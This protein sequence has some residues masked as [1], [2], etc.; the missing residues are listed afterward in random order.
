[1]SEE[2]KISPKMEEMEEK[3][4]VNTSED[5]SSDVTS[6]EVKNNPTKK[7]SPMAMILGGFVLAVVVGFFIFYAV[8]SAQ[9]KKISRSDF[10]VKSATLFHIPVASIDGKK[11]LY[12]D[13]VDNLKAME[14]FYETDDT[15]EQEPSDSE[16]SDFILSRLLVNNLIVDLAKEMDVE[17]TKEEINAIAKEQII[18]GFPSE[19]D[20][21]KQIMDRYGWTLDEFLEKIVYPTELEK[22]VAAKYAEEHPADG[23]VEEGVRT[24]ALGILNQIKEGADFAEMA[25][26]YGSDGTAEQGGDLGWFTHDQMVPEFADA[27]FSLNKGD[28]SSELVKT[29]FGYH[30]LQVTDKRTTQDENGNDVEEVQARHILFLVQDN[31]E[32]AFRSLVNDRLKNAKIKIMADIH[33]PFEGVFDEPIL[34]LENSDTEENS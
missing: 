18:P 8:V 21:E 22:K 10:T 24:Q 31:T 4:P 27:A 14:Q 1:M 33:D 9:V 29:Q 16:E 13:Y 25:K 28:L 19:E 32:D 5:T 20:A 34:D 12:A 11:V 17:V 6:G 15:G 23:S 3:I 2:Q 7:F 26:Q 30:I